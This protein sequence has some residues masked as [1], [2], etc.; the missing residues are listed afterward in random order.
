MNCTFTITGDNGAA[1]TVD[2]ARPLPGA[3]DVT[4]AVRGDRPSGVADPT[5]AC[6]GSLSFHLTGPGVTLDTTLDDGDA[7]ADQMTANFQAGRTYTT[8]DDR[9]PAGR[10]HLHGAA[11]AAS[12]AAAAR[13]RRARRAST[14][15]AKP[16]AEP[17][18]P[19]CSAR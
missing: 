6:G 18:G 13:S 8:F 4:A 10:A 11:G 9:R 16:A 7:S 12:T 1:I 3:G 19:G 2:P 5:L 14:K 15:P 17:I